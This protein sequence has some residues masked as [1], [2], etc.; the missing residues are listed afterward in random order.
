[1]KRPVITDPVHIEVQGFLDGFGMG[2]KVIEFEECTK[3]SELAANA[4][5]VGVGQIAKSMVLLADSEPILFVTCGDVK[6]NTN[7]LRKLLG[8]RKVSFADAETV[9]DVTGYPVGGVCPFKVNSKVRV[10]LDNTLKRFDVVYA[11][12]GTSFSA[13]PVNL[14]QLAK[15][16]G[17]NIVDLEQPY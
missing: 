15:I 11:A 16:T 6:I 8:V 9:L 17:G 13:V 7:R 4:L 12:A 1:M 2:I 3:T 5:G 10:F 14:E